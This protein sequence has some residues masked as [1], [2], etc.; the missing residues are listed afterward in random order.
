M[1]TICFSLCFSRLSLTLLAFYRD[2]FYVDV[3]LFRYLFTSLSYSLD[4][5][6]SLF[7]FRFSSCLYPFP[8]FL[9]LVSFFTGPLR[10]SFAAS[11]LAFSFQFFFFLSHAVLPSRSIRSYHSP[12]PISRALKDLFSRSSFLQNGRFTLRNRP[13]ISAAPVDNLFRANGV[14]TLSWSSS[15]LSHA[16]M[17]R[18]CHAPITPNL[19]S[20]QIS[21]FD[22]LLHHTLKKKTRWHQLSRVQRS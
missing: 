19:Q 18:S 10:T 4:S 2:S 16:K 11:P 6:C 14:T 13:S 20:S 21:I 12:Y 9:T 1:L 5:S 15:M 7:F 3:I 22:V 17:S 8:H